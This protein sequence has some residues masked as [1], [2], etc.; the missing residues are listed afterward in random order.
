M[1]QCINDES[2]SLLLYLRKKEKELRR[3]TGGKADRSSD[4]A[5]RLSML[6]AAYRNKISSLNEDERSSVVITLQ[7]ALMT[8]P[9]NREFMDLCIKRG[10]FHNLV[11]IA[12]SY[13]ALD[14]KALPGD[15]IKN[16]IEKSGYKRE[17]KLLPLL[18][19][20]GSVMAEEEKAVLSEKITAKP[21]K[22]TLQGLYYALS[23]HLI[24]MEPSV[25]DYF[26]KQLR[27]YGQKHGNNRKASFEDPVYVLLR[28]YK[29][30]SINAISC[31]LD[32]IGDERIIN[33]AFYP[34]RLT[35]ADFEPNWWRILSMH[36][37]RRILTRPGGEAVFDRIMSVKSPAFCS[38][39]AAI[40]SA[41]R[42]MAYRRIK[43][44][45]EKKAGKKEKE[46]EI[47]SC[48]EE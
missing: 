42:D 11:Q 21:E 35:A 36:D 2:I 31:F 25:S 1:Q 30:G 13:I 29:E 41:Y 12:R 28:L 39:K 5:D 15:F 24:K 43:N 22:C 32:G 6:L 14:E 44:K 38:L 3:K 23:D 46:M 33:I 37:H 4:P 17:D 10:L 26:A 19:Q 48:L 8:G 16:L 20:I 7:L 27:E 47:L 45:K 40:C 18:C 9:S 34:E